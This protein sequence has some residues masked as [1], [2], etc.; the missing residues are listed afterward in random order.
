MRRL[1]LVAL[2]LVTTAGCGTPQ[3]LGAP[4]SEDRVPILFAALRRYLTTPEENSFGN[5]VF[6]N[7]YV[8]D[9][10][11]TSGE[12]LVDPIDPADQQRIAEALADLTPVTFVADQAEVVEE[13]DG[14]AQVRDGILITLGEPVGAGDRRTVDVNGFVACLGATWL[15]YV[16]ERSGGAWVVTGTDGS[17][18]IA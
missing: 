18:A 4:P 12:E 14:C 7:V 17:I 13:T 11:Q 6:E 3:D 8:L 9:H 5:N 10:T 16:V 15:T 1:L 2:L